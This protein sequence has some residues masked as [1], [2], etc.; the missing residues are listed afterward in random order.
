MRFPIHVSQNMTVLLSLGPVLLSFGP[1]E[2]CIQANTTVKHGQ[3]SA[4]YRPT[5]LTRASRLQR[6]NELHQK[7]LR[8]NLKYGSILGPESEVILGADTFLALFL[9]VVFHAWEGATTA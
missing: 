1:V 8:I 3:N 7:D 9:I 4:K 6:N 5:V 2:H